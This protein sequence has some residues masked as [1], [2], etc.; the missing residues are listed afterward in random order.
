MKMK[1]KKQAAPEE[2]RLDGGDALGGYRSGGTSAQGERRRTAADLRPSGR[3]SPDWE[4][5]A[6]DAPI[7]REDVRGSLEG[8]RFW[9]PAESG[10]YMQY[11][12]GLGRARQSFYQIA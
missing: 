7:T 4:A 3:G 11:E 8:R 5:A 10:C 6:P 12:M 1:R 9:M 2:V